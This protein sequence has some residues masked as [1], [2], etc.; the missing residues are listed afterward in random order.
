MTPFGQYIR[1]LRSEK[2]ITLRQMAQDISVTPA[3]LSALEHGWRGLPQPSFIQQVCSYL[4]IWGE[5][6]EYVRELVKISDPKISINTGGLTP[7][8]T[9]FANILAQNIHLLDDYT[10]EWMLHEIEGP[11]RRKNNQYIAPPSNL[12]LRSKAKN[13]TD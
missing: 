13:Y 1:R 11:Q 5:D 3:Y 2:N 10:L 7:K 9:E 8:A 12:K 6:A 4:E